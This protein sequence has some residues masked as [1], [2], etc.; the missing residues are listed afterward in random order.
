MT[1]LVRMALRMPD[2]ILVGEVRGPEALDLL[3]ACRQ[4]SSRG[5]DLLQSLNLGRF[6][7]QLAPLLLGRPNPRADLFCGFG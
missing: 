1:Q 7:W 2:R 3:M 6:D 5:L 4:F